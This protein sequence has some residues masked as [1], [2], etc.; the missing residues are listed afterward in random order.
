M[1]I[2]GTKESIEEMK[3][4]SPRRGR[5][6]ARSSPV[7]LRPPCEQ[8][9]FDL[10]GEEPA[11]RSWGVDA[12]CS[13]IRITFYRAA[14]GRKRVSG[15]IGGRTSTDNREAVI[16]GDLRW[17]GRPVKHCACSNLARGVSRCGRDHEM[18]CLT[19]RGPRKHPSYP[20]YARS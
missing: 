18:R 7:G 12:F 1:R 14:F 17:H 8:R 19:Y 15:E 4:T 10:A 5:S 9:A 20:P 2:L 16:P 13:F 3:R 6:P 11:G